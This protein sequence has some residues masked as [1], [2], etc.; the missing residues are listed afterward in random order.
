MSTPQ[1]TLGA[2]LKA[3]PTGAGHAGV[4]RGPPR[5]ARGSPRRRRSS[6]GSSTSGPEAQDLLAI[7]PATLPV[8]RAARRL[9]LLRARPPPP[10]MDALRARPDAILVSAETAKDYSIVP[11]DRIRDPRARTR[12]AT[13]RRSTSRWPGSR[14]SSRRR[15]RTPSSSRTSRTS[16]RRRATTGSRSSSPAPTATSASAAA[17]SPRRLGDGWQVADLGT[18]TARLANSITSVDLS[19][20]SCS[21]SAF[22]VAHRRRRGRAV[23]AGRAG[24]AAARA[25]HAHRDR[26]RAA[27]GPALDGRRDAVRRRRGDRDGPPRRSALVGLA[28]LQILA[29]VFDPPAD[30]PGDPAGPHRGDGR[31]HRLGTRG[32]ASRSPIAVCRG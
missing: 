17:A 13:S 15:R 3:V 11:G 20:S 28:L 30:A 6:T 25:R 16:P 32:G 23:P 21:T 12:P 31:G 8:G 27:P 5:R 9:V 2:D 18:T 19:A 10:R 1:L 26:R 14:S 29:G 4:G 22:A 7:D 24:R